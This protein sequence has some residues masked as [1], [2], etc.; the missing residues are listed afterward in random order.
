MQPHRAVVL[1]VVVVHREEDVRQAA[2]RVPRHAREQHALQLASEA[3][4]VL[5]AEAL[6]ALAAV[7][8]VAERVL[9]LARD[10]Q[11]WRPVRAASRNFCTL[12]GQSSKA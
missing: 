3:H 7:D 8:E 4:L 11:A 12:N 5:D 1:L 2:D 10:Q 9:A 6:R